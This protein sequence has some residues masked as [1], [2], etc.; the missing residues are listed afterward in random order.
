MIR[1][2]TLLAALAACALPAGAASHTLHFQQGLNGYTGTVD[3]YVRGADPDAALGSE[4]EVSVDASDGGAP[5]HTLLRF[6]RL[7]GSA[8]GQ[9]GSGEVIESATLT[10]QI[11]SAGSG[12]RLHHMLTAWTAAAT[13]NSLGEGVQADGVE[14]QA[15][16]FLTV[17]GNTSDAHIDEAPLVLDITAALSDP[18]L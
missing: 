16:P 3:T 1:T 11:S 4:F 14:A 17:G 5:S 8:S 12:I 7:F 10:L 6:D 2:T 18:W 9:I 15:S 13:W